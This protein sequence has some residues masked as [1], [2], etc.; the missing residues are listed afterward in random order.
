MIKDIFTNKLTW[1]I[2]IPILTYMIG[3][4]IKGLIKF[5]NKIRG[6]KNGN[7]NK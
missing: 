3:S 7:T 4:L 5:I 1:L 2:L 6:D